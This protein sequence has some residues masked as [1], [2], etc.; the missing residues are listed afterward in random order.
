MKKV[1]LAGLSVVIGSVSLLAGLSTPAF[2]AT[3]KRTSEP[4]IIVGTT[5]LVSSAPLFLAAGLGYW[6]KL[7]LNVQL[8]TFSAAGA[9][10]LATAA[11]SL[12]VSATGITAGLFNLWN[13]GQK[14]YIVADKGRIWP[15]QHFEALVVSNQAWKSGVRSVKALKGKRFGN[16]ATGSTFD[17]LLGTMLDKNGLSIKDIQ[18]VPLTQLKNMTSAVESG[19]VDAT[20]L[21]QPAANMAL[22]SGKVHLLAWVDNQVKADLLVIAFSPKFMQQKANAVK[23]LEGYVEALH[24]YTQHVY[25]N[26]QMNDPYLKKALGIISQYTSTPA[27]AIPNEL[28]YVNPNGFVDPANIQNQ[29]NFYNKNQ[30]VTKAIS[31]KQMVNE[32]YLQQAIKALGV[33]K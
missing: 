3:S 7:G 19:Q 28:I 15:G 18:D 10:D 22:A 26:H 1:S 24:Y 29:L 14:E 20:I 27:S 12:D 16:T 11:N 8:Q 6:K 17:Y 31:V 33:G 5:P 32:S 9:I 13:S 2:G 23:F 21:P 30:Y 4:P 25:R